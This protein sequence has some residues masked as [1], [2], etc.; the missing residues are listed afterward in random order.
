MSKQWIQLTVLG[1]LLLAPL[2]GACSPLT[3]APDAASIPVADR[4]PTVFTHKQSLAFMPCIGQIAPAFLFRTLGAAGALFFARHEVA[5]PLAS[6]ANPAEGSFD[7]SEPDRPGEPRILRLCFE[8]AD[9]D[10]Q[11]VGENQMRGIVNYHVGNDPTRWRSSIPTYRG[12]LYKQLYPGIDLLYN[13]DEGILKGTYT[14]APGA[15]PADIRWRFDGASGISLDEGELLIRLVETDEHAAL[16]EREPTAWQ[17]IGDKRISV[18]IRYHIHDDGSIGFALGRYDASQP[19]TIDPTLDY[20]T[21]VGGCDGEGSYGI[22]T[23]HDNN[24]Y[25]AGRTRS[26]DYPAADPKTG[27]DNHD[28]F[29]TK[30]DPSQTGADQLIYTTFIGGA[31]KDTAHGIAADAA[32][33]AYVI[34]YARSADLPT[35]DNAFQR[36]FAGGWSDGVVIRLDTAGTPTYVSYLGGNQWEDPI[37]MAIEDGLIYVTGDTD[38]DNYPTTANAYQGNRAGHTDGFVAVFDPAQSGDAS[39]VYSTYFGGSSSDEAWAIAVR[40]GII[41]FAGNTQST[42]LPTRNPFQAEYS[43]ASSWG[44]DAYLA[45][46]APSLTGDEQLVYGTYFGGTRDEISGGVAVD[47]AG[48]MYWCGATESTDFP[49]TVGSPSFGGGKYDAFLVKL[50]PAGSSCIYS[51]L[52]GGSGNDGLRGIV[53]DAAG[54]AYVTGGTG[55]DDFPLVDPIQDT[56]AGGNG[57]EGLGPGDAIIARFDAAGTMLF[58]TYL[59]GRGDEAG[60][61][62]ALD[63]SGNVYIAGGTKSSELATENPF[64]AAHSGNFDNF[65]AIFGGFGPAPPTPTPTLTPTDTP[66]PTPTNTLTPTRVWGPYKLYLPLILK[67]APSA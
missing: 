23:D 1:T 65:V 67:N 39:L 12:I 18:R 15:N 53:V 57:Y 6:T 36:S 26:L 43:G 35:T 21:Y 41:Y 32:G 47:S 44:G 52:I 37:Q 33:N 13:G 56:W 38:S 17:V 27:K 59:G 8:G 48:N 34:G 25:I 66:V 5:L 24:V 9:S 46:L 11:V 31:A 55:S 51:L 58:S 22:A 16:I 64:Q 4:Q 19:L 61:G 50:N 60:L 10:T 29:V 63:Q 20:G 45:K 30:L 42:D 2:L 14:I 49:T 3:E 28:I 54:D 40:D 62:I 7:G